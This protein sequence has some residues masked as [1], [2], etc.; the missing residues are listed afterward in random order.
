MDSSKLQTTDLP[1]TD[2]PTTDLPATDLPATDLP[3]TDLPATDLPTTDLPS[4]DLPAMDLSV[5]ELNSN[6]VNNIDHQSA[7]PSDLQAKDLT[8]SDVNNIDHQSATP[9]DLQAKDLS[10]NESELSP[11]VEYP[12]TSTEIAAELLGYLGTPEVHLNKLLGMFKIINQKLDIDIQDKTNAEAFAEANETDIS[13]FKFMDAST[14]SIKASVTRKYKYRLQLMYIPVFLDAAFLYFMRNVTD[15]VNFYKMPDNE[16]ELNLVASIYGMPPPLVAEFRK[17]ITEDFLRDIS[18]ESPPF[19][20]TTTLTEPEIM[21][22][23]PEVAAV[24]KNIL[25]LLMSKKK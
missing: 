25:N 22:R 13:T 19:I 12:K 24:F 14:Q 15:V 18:T 7:T 1:T 21:R 17:F 20:V 8:I 2:L 9:S 11:L 16:L 23:I 6:E 3:A 5:S 4:T 10:V